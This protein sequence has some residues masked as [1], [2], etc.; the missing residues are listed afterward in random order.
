MTANRCSGKTEIGYWGVDTTP[1]GVGS[2]I[3][4]SI[5]VLIC[6]EPYSRVGPP[7]IS[8]QSSDLPRTNHGPSWGTVCVIRTSRRLLFFSLSMAPFRTKLSPNCRLVLNPDQT[9]NQNIRTR[10]HPETRRS[11]IGPHNRLSGVLPTRLDTR[12]LRIVLDLFDT[13]PVDSVITHSVCQYTHANSCKSSTL[14]WLRLNMRQG[15]M[16]LSI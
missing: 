5:A 12:G 10:S 3:A 4:A 16:I 7:I 14:G 15:N 2:S 8:G 6:C 13:A 9:G 1:G 11:R